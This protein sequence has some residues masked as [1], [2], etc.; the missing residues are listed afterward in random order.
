MGDVNWEDLVTAEK[1][2]EQ[3]LQDSQIYFDQA[4]HAVTK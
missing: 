4:Q 3:F 2:V 1:L